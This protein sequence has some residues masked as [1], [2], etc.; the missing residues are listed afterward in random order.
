[1]SQER[2]ARQVLLATPT[3]K[4]L[5]GCP[6]TRWSDYISD[7]AWSRLGVE[8]AELSEIPIDWP[9][10]SSSPRAAA[11]TTLPRGKADRRMTKL[12]KYFTQTYWQRYKYEWGMFH[13]MVHMPH[14]CA[15]PSTN[16]KLGA[17]PCTNC[18]TI[19]GGS[20]FLIVWWKIVQRK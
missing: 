20:G 13:I 10:G 9:W 2:L 5:R 11:P 4:R 1:M 17:L 19:T 12:L 8:P 3:E 14:L 6:R 18:C 16:R 7:L 15:V